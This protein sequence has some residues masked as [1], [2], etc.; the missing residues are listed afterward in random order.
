M[1]AKALVKYLLFHNLLRSKQ[2]LF[3]NLVPEAGDVQCF[4]MVETVHPE[5]LFT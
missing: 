5:M 4:M 2:I 3:V 1:P